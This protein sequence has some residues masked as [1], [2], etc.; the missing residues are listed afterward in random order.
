MHFKVIVHANWGCL[1]WLEYLS[2]REECN[3][4]SDTDLNETHNS[5]NSRANKIAWLPVDLC[6]AP[7]CTTVLS[8]IPQ[9]P[10]C[11]HGL[12]SP[13]PPEQQG[14]CLPPSHARFYHQC[15][16]CLLRALHGPHV[17]QMF[18]HVVNPAHGKS[19]RTSPTVKLKH[20]P[21]GIGYLCNCW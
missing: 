5:I 11:L 7:F 9:L 6:P 16:P 19:A 2:Q 21:E 1:P 3:S 8:D 15:S 18:L 14:V 13:W 17:Q 20:H 4:K 12:T 10:H